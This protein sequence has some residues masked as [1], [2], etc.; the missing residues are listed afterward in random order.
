M[1]DAPMKQ[2]VTNE[3]NEGQ[4]TQSPPQRRRQ[5]DGCWGLS[6]LSLVGL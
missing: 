4:Y 6:V 2:P 5:P 1:K 3:T